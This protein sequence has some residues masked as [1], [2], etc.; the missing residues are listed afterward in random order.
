MSTRQVYVN[1]KPAVGTELVV[2]TAQT[3]PEGTEV[4]IVQNNKVCAIGQVVE[5]K[6]G[7]QYTVLVVV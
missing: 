2:V 3:P 7:H 6:N 5:V 1:D 4:E